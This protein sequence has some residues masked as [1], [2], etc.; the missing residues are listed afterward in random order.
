MFVRARGFSVCLH[1]EHS[2]CQLRREWYYEH[3]KGGG[4]KGVTEGSG[5]QGEGFHE[6]AAIEVL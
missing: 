4:S 2:S 1:K 3:N 5:A 6:D